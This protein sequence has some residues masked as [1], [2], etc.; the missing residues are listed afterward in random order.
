TEPTQLAA[1]AQ[2]VVML[3]ASFAQELLWAVDR[4]SP[5]GVAY[6]V[7]RT[8]RLRGALDV[9]ALRRAFDALIERH[10][11]LRTT[12]ATHEDQAV[13]VVH[14]PRAVPFEIVDL[15]SVAPVER[16]DGAAKVVR[17]RS[18]R[19]FDLSKDLLLRVTLVTLGDTEHVLLFESHHIAFDGW[20]RDI[21]FR[22]L[23]ELYAAFAAGRAPSL[24][25]L[26]IQYADFSIWQREQLQG[27]RLD[28]LLGWWRT[29]LGDADHVLRLPTDFPRPTVSRFEGITRSVTVPG[30]LQQE[31]RALGQ[32]F[33]ATPYMVLLAAYVTVLHRYTGQS[34]VLV[35]SPIAGRA[36]PETEGLI[37]YFANTIVQRARFTGDPSFAQLLQRLRDSALGAYDHQDVPFEKLALELEGRASLGQSPLFQ[38][39]FTQLDSSQAPEA[40]MG[41][42]TLEPF[43]L[44]NATTKFDLTLFMSQRADRLE[45]SLRGRSD[46]H[47]ADTLERALG[48]IVSVLAA[49]TRNPD[50]LVSTIDLAG[51]DERQ[52][53]DAANETKVDEGSFGTAGELFEQQ[54]ARVP[55]RAAVIASPAAGGSEESLSYAQV[56]ARAN[57]IAARLK[58]LDVRPGVRVALGLDRSLEGL[59]ALLAI[60]K[61][62]GAYVPVPPEL[63]PARR[64]QL[65]KEC[66]ARV[67]IGLASDTWDLPADVSLVALD[68]DAAALDKQ[69]VSNPTTSASPSDVAYVLYTSGSTGVPKGVAVTHANIVHYARA[70]SRVLGDV[71]ASAPGNGFTALD[72]LHFGMIS[73]LGADLG[74]TSLFPALLSGSTLHMLGKAVASEP[75]AFAR[76]VSAHPLDILKITP[77]HLNAL[78]AGKTGGELAAILPRRWLVLGGEALRPELVRTLLRGA[79]CRILNHY[80]PTE[81]SVGV[82]TFEATFE[83]VEA[84]QAAGAQTVPVGRPLAN[85]AAFVVDA[86][87]S[88]QPVGIPGELFIGGDG[89][90]KEYLGRPEQTADR[91]I[92]FRGQRVYRSGDLVRR[93]PDG[94]IEFLGRVDDQVKVRGYRVELGEIAQVLRTHPAALDAF[95]I[96]RSDEGAE[97]QLVA[98]VV[99]KKEGYAAS[100]AEKPTGRTITEWLAGRLPEYMVP[101]AVVLLEALP[102]TANGKVDRNLL[103]APEGDADDSS[104][105]VDPRDDTERQLVLIWQEVLKKPV[106]GVADNFFDLGGH[107][108]LAIR[109]LGKISKVFG[110]RMSLRTLF[111]SPTIELLAKQV[112]SPLVE[113]REPTVL[114]LQEEGTGAAIV[115]LHGDWTGAGWYMR[116]LAPLVA[117]ESPFY[118]LPPN[119]ADESDFPWTIEAMAERHIAELRKVRPH[120]PYHVVGYCV[121]GLVAYEIARQLR[122]AGE[123]VER[124]VAIDSIPLNAG[125]RG[126]RSL[127]TPLL[128]KGDADARLTREA[129]LMK[130]ARWA[131][132]QFRQFRQRSLAG[133]VTWTARKVGRLTGIVASEQVVDAP[134]AP[135]SDEPEQIPD[136]RVRTTQQRAASAY[137]PGPYEDI[138]DVV[139]AVGPKGAPPRPSPIARWN[140]LGKTRLHTIESNHI[141]LITNNLHMLADVLRGILGMRGA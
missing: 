125:L 115:Y 53:L 117:P 5:G 114:P 44:D 138:V 90:A 67:L 86:H 62:G 128:P 46:L 130:K 121:N 7:P 28:A 70:V 71:P 97:P 65:L 63:P 123:T 109:I 85:T 48:H 20:S 61:A 83:S 8:R 79:P 52:W 22:E 108:L 132:L 32:R 74:N 51:P 16:D 102:L 55:S 113:S 54:A 19:P 127:I 27:E 92:S 57:Q 1:D 41:D 37:G 49:A 141:G 4:A 73:T 15:S 18:A 36:R 120:G 17:D 10:E 66:G 95:V 12:Y 91:F 82:L 81:T 99:P 88:E 39:V 35:G 140:L 47:H 72:N 23:S 38:V 93:L 45:L 137:V 75:A 69:S 29:E 6:N 131:R 30:E 104:A 50:V 124:V 139:W 14:P 118:V 89:V 96:L 34:D 25:P 33:S 31:L 11:I 78:S 9:D 129:E 119:D 40:R 58:E 106:I 68:R 13:Q 122:A 126:M 3:P 134:K 116:R 43:A 80:G 98:Y 107:S 101:S 59:V 60:L 77:N 112:G 24:P 64:Q 76:Y 135:V 136:E 133:K 56:N 110:Q 94:A 26:P 84:A 100:H 111:E 21:V 103:P 87:G 2:D 105:H 42:V